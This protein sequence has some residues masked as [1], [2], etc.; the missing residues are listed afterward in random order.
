MRIDGYPP[1]VPPPQPT[2]GKSPV[3]NTSAAPEEKI[4]A[5]DKLARLL[6]EKR[7]MSEAAFGGDSSGELG[8]NIDLR[9]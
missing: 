4:S 9:V 7:W 8:K 1:F 2:S 6:D 3:Q 5:Q